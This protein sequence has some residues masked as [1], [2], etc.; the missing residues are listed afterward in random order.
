MKADVVPQSMPRKEMQG[1]G[2]LKTVIALKTQA[3]KEFKKI[4]SPAILLAVC[5]TGHPCEKEV[6]VY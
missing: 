2:S 5:G 3:V 1:G 4:P 6:M